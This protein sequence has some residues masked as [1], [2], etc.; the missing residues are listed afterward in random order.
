MEVPLESRWV[1]WA[2]PVFIRTEERDWNDFLESQRHRRYP[3]IDAEL[4]DAIRGLNR[5]VVLRLQGGFRYSL[6]LEQRPAG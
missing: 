3:D 6:V 5:I 1:D 4:V 2:A